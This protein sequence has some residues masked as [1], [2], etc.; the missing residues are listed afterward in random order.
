[1]SVI[2]VRLIN[3]ITYL[4]EPSNIKSCNKAW[5]VESQLIRMGLM[6]KQ[7]SQSFLD[8]IDYLN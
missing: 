5:S 8:K 4:G 2:C 3:L 7:L 6:G 1:M